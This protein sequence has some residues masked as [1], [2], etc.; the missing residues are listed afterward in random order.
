MFIIVSFIGGHICYALSKTFMDGINNKVGIKFNADV[1]KDISI[2]QQNKIIS[3]IEKIYEMDFGLKEKINKYRNGELDG[4]ALGIKK[5]CFPFAR[6]DISNYY[7]FVS[8]A[9][10]QRSIAFLLLMLSCI[11]FCDI[12]IFKLYS[13]GIIRDIIV[14]T[15]LLLFSILIFKRSIKMRKTA[16]R[17]VYSQFLFNT[18]K[19]NWEGRQ[20][21]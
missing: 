5:L 6:E 16:D 9:D 8:L 3:E 12:F 14:P 7:V 20:I 17:V 11:F 21:T 13:F 18:A 4:R 2:E 10:F 1:F 19:N 15:I